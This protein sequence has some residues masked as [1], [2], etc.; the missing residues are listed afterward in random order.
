MKEIEYSLVPRFPCVEL[1]TLEFQVLC[2]NLLP[3]LGLH[4]NERLPPFITVIHSEPAK[5]DERFLVSFWFPIVDETGQYQNTG[6]YCLDQSEFLEYFYLG[7]GKD[8]LNPDFIYVSDS[9][10][11]TSS[12]SCV[13]NN[14]PRNNAL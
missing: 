9:H 13:G 7:F 12:V 6:Y 1:T 4:R 14:K 2:D 8:F 3:F 11:L 10:V 5:P